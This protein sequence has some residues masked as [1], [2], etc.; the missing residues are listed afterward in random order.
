[1]TKSKRGRYTLEF[2]QEAAQLV[3]SG[4]SQ[5]ATARSLGVVELMRGNSPRNACSLLTN[6]AAVLQL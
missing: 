6:P 3:E 5:A 2:K 1:M 4:L